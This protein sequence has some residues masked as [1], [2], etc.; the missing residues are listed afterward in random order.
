MYAILP[1][2]EDDR[3]YIT[4]KKALLSREQKTGFGMVVGFGALALIFGVFFLWKHVASPFVLAYTGPKF[5]TGDEKKQQEM[6]AL[7]KEDTDGDGLSD[8]AELYVYKTSPYIADSDSDGTND[9]K[10][11][12]SGQDP[13]CAPNMPCAAVA[14]A[15]NPSTLK[16][17]FAEAAANAAAATT[18]GGAPTTIAPTT[19][20]IT[21]TLAQMSADEI[22]QMLIDSGADQASVNALTDDQLRAA[23]AQA[24]QSLQLQGAATSDASS[25]SS[26][27]TDST[28]APTP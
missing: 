28:Q 7:K 23:L 13:N 27:A 5:L 14:D 6:E 25:S 18:A 4:R 20:D 21:A 16:G 10:E 9:A 2:S 24:L 26:T 8:Y 19:E 17:S 1:M 22:R 12:Q 15:V 11:V 3:L